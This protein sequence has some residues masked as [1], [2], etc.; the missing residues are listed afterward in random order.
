MVNPENVSKMVQSFDKIC[1]KQLS[2]DVYTVLIFCLARYDK[3]LARD[4]ISLEE[5]AENIKSAF[6]DVS[7]EIDDFLKDDKKIP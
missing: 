4:D 7:K 2:H 5:R 6:I 1:E 3:I